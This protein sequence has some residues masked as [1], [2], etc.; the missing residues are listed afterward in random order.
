MNLMDLKC[1]IDKVIVVI[2]VQLKELVKFCVDIKV[3]VQVGII[4]VNFDEFI[5][6]IIVEVMEKVGKEGV[7]IVEE[8]LGLENELFVV[9]GMQFDCGYLFFYFVNKLD[10]MVVE[11]DSLLLLLVDKKIFN[12][13]EMLLVLEV[14]VKVGCLLLIVVEDVEGEVLVILVVNNMCGIVKVV[15]VKVLGFGDCCKVMLQDIVIFIGG[16]VIS[17]EV[18]LSLEGVILEYLGNVKC[19]VINK[20]N[21]IIIDGV[22]VQ[23]DIEVCVLQICKQIEEI[24]FD[25]DCEKL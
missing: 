4:F 25:Y 9:E 13:C 22:G 7:I 20:E 8:G 12:I 3:I 23:V 10:I 21:I 16:I 1:G 2:V 15:V 17:E 5:G 11:L 18:G 6:Q 19:V 24:I 14:V